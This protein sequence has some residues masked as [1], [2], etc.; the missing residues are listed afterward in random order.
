MLN[1][2]KDDA[3]QRGGNYVFRAIPGTLVESASTLLHR[4]KAEI[5]PNEGNV[6]SPVTHL[7][8]L[9]QLKILFSTGI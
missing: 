8:V 7:T 2:L 5:V 1:P 9:Q 3:K 6:F 4:T